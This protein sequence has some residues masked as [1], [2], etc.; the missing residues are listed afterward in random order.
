MLDA[1]TDDMGNPSEGQT[2]LDCLKRLSS[3]YGIEGCLAPM[4]PRL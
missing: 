3:P 1:A 4:L 2:L